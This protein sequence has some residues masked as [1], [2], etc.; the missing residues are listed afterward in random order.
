MKLSLYPNGNVGNPS[1]KYKKLWE[2]RIEQSIAYGSIL[3]RFGTTMLSICEID[4]LLESI[5][6]YGEGIIPFVAGWKGLL[7]Y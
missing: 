6:Y 4:E 7:P 5:Y 3:V 2:L 1:L